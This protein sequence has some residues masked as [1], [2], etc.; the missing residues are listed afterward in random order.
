MGLSCQGSRE[1]K[2]EGFEAKRP[3]FQL[4]LQDFLVPWLWPGNLGPI[5]FLLSTNEKQ[6]I[7]LVPK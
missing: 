1:E 2:R 6:I 5:G 3:G 4:Q 7:I